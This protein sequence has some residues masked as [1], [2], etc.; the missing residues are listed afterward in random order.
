[1]KK[2]VESSSEELFLQSILARI[3][4]SHHIVLMDKEVH[5]GKRFW[6]MLNSLEHGNSRNVLG[7]QIE[8]GLYDRQVSNKKTTN[9]IYTLPPI[10]SDYA[11]YLLKDPYIFDFVQA[12]GKATNVILKN[13]SQVI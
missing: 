4:W 5:L 10:Q 6:Y 8:S 3:S 1:M 11:N 9:F 13:S 7:M 12:K 2:E